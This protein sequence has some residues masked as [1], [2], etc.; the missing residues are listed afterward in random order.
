MIDVKKMLK[1]RNEFRK[2]SVSVH[3]RLSTSSKDSRDN[4]SYILPSNFVKQ[5]FLLKRNLQSNPEFLPQ[6][7]FQK[8]ARGSKPPQVPSHFFKKAK[9]AKPKVQLNSTGEARLGFMVSPERQR[10]PVTG[11]EVEVR[12]P[13]E[14]PSRALTMSKSLPR[15][16]K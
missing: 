2:Y 4:Y 1:N 13:K 10:K 15:F 12:L 3:S 6:Q 14:S 11:D 16:P 7:E 8:F 9:E 5:K